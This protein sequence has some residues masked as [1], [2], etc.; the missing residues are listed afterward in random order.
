MSPTERRPRGQHHKRLALA[1]CAAFAIGLPLAALQMAT[2]DR[3]V[4]DVPYGEP[5]DGTWRLVRV[6]G[7]PIYERYEIAVRFGRIEGGYDGCNAWGFS[8]QRDDFGNRLIVSDAQGCDPK[9]FDGVYNALR[10]AEA[11]TDGRTPEAL[12]RKL[13]ELEIVLDRVEEGGRWP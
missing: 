9:P 1:I 12:Q 2:D 13:G 3:G 10:N 11:R 7:E 5:E 6:A 8:D 4:A